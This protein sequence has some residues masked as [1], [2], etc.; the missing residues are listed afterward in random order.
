MDRA[1]PARQDPSTRNLPS[2]TLYQLGAPAQV[3]R[4]F[5]QGQVP[6]SC[7][8]FSLQDDQG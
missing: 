6:D 5:T 7:F 1:V 3:V 8:D 4:S 2:V